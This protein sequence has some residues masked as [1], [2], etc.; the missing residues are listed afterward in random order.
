MAIELAP[1]KI[2]VNALAPVAGETPLLKSF[3]GGDTPE[4]R[5]LDSNILGLANLVVVDSVSQCEERGE[6]KYAL[7]K[8]IINRS[9]LVELGDIIM[10]KNN[11]RLSE[12]DITVA[13]LTGVAVQD[14]MITNKVYNNLNQL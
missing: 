2:R 5:E 6:T 11:G 9:D 8:N 12:N 3:M 1:K 7:D 4:K 10:K 13:D 14:I